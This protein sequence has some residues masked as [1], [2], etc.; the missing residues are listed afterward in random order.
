MVKVSAD[1]CRENNLAPMLFQSLAQKFFAVSVSVDVC[2]VVEVAAKPKCTL[3]CCDGDIVI[4]GSVTV[5]VIVSSYSPC[6]K[7]YLAHFETCLSKYPLFHE[8][9]FLR[10]LEDPDGQREDHSSNIEGHDCEAHKDRAL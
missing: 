7:P 4:R 3:N 9:Q 2:R 5:P 10:I 1:F 8:N 6:S